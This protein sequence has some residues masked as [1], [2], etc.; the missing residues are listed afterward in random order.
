MLRRMLPAVAMAVL[1]SHA[2]GQSLSRRALYDQWQ[3]HYQALDANPKCSGKETVYLDAYRFTFAYFQVRLATLPAP[4]PSELAPLMAAVDTVQ[5]RA[6]ECLR[7]PVSSGSLR[8]D[9]LPTA[10]E[11]TAWDKFI[12]G[13]SA[14]LSGG[15]GTSVGANPAARTGA[16]AR[17]G[18][19]P[20]VPEP[21]P[22][23]AGGADPNEVAQL[24]A[25]LDAARRDRD[26]IQGQL[27]QASAELFN[28]KSELALVAPIAT[29]LEGLWQVQ[30]TLGTEKETEYF[31]LTATPDGTPRVQVLD[32]D[33]RPDY[34][35]RDARGSYVYVIR[36]RGDSVIMRLDISRVQPGNMRMI[37]GTM[38]HGSSAASFFG[39]KLGDPRI[40]Q[41]MIPREDD[42]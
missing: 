1:S 26:L 25:D 6:E 5:K 12:G 8:K 21:P 7:I 14:A 37:L 42:D 41:M 3:R 18:A 30:M 13:L 23:Q 19:V 16:A 38:E 29:S 33:V 32:Q 17:G 22:D 11:P 34:A 10:G 15:G 4:S 35:G 28:T 40:A 2:Q 9:E 20:V 31:I 24:R 27:N 39:L 36:E